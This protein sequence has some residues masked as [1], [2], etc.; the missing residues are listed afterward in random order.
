[1]SLELRR[2]ISTHD[3]DLEEIR[4]DD[5]NDMEEEEVITVEYNNLTSQRVSINR[6]IEDLPYR[7]NSDALERE[8]NVCLII[9]FRLINIEPS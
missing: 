2:E 8:F 1:M 9:L 4:D 5:P 6:F 7:K 3:S